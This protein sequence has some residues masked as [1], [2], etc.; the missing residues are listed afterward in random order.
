MVNRDIENELAVKRTIANLIKQEKTVVMIAH[1]LSIVKN[2][3]QILVVAGGRIAKQGSHK[4]LLAKGGARDV[5]G[6]SHERYMRPLKSETERPERTGRSVFCP[7]PGR[8]VVSSPDAACALFQVYYAVSRGG[9]LTLL[10]LHYIISNI[11]YCGC[12]QDI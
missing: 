9:K 10:R 4:E 8:P 7:P 2:A 5:Y 3:N 1:T 6:E 12:T 11:R